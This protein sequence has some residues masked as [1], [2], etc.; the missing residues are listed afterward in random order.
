MPNLELKIDVLVLTIVKGTGS[1]NN[2][3]EILRNLA[4]PSVCKIVG[5]W[6]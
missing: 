2:Q 6:Y 3:F 5:A 1:L 4:H